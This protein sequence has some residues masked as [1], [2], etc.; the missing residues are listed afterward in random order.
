MLGGNGGALRRRAK[1]RLR[2][3]VAAHAALAMLPAA[4]GYL[5]EGLGY[6]PGGGYCY[7]LFSGSL[8]GLLLAQLM[9]LAFWA[10]FGK[11]R[12]VWRLVG[13]AVGCIYLAIWPTIG[14]II[15]PLRSVSGAIVRRGGAEI[16][17]RGIALWNDFPRTLFHSAG[18]VGVSVALF[19]AGFLIVR[20][21]LNELEWRPEAESAPRGGRPQYALVSAVAVTAS[22]ALFFIVRHRVLF[23]GPALVEWGR[24]VP[25]YAC[26]AFPISTICVIWA[27]LGVGR[28]RRRVVL[29]FVLAALMAI[30]IWIGGVWDHYAALRYYYGDLDWWGIPRWGMASLLPVAILLATLLAVRACGYRLTRHAAAGRQVT[31]RELLAALTLACAGLAFIIV[32]AERQQRAVAAIEAAGGNVEYAATDQTLWGFYPAY[33]LRDWLPRDYFDD[34]DDVWLDYCNVADDVLVDLRA[35]K[36]L[37]FLRLAGN[38]ITDTALSHVRGL[39]RL[40]ELYL[41]DCPITDAG[42]ANLRELTQLEHLD[43]RNTDITDAGM[44]HLRELTSLEALALDDTQITDAGLGYL[45]GLEHLQHLGLRGTGATEAS[46]LRLRQ[47]LPNVTIYWP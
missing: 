20:R 8:E 28:A 29:S 15:S 7:Y 33:Y 41:D 23:D 9:L 31:L 40:K 22:V 11:A 37:Q 35:L 21:L 34:V 24:G 3:L 36:D 43:L 38:P 17:P 5:P 18:A 10:G 13:V 16:V 47:A 27:A 25:E 2:W 19:A 45:E 32:P 42:L 39:T 30:S 14:P 4:S 44:I 12:I 1:V 26:V 46:V 6:L